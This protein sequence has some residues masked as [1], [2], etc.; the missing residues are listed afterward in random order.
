MAITNDDHIV[1]NMNDH[2]L[3][4]MKLERKQVIGKTGIELGLFHEEF[5]PGIWEDLSKNEKLQNREISIKTKAG[6]EI[7]CLFSTEK[8]ELENK[9]SWLITIVDVS[10]RKKAEKELADVYNRVTDGFVALDKNWNYTYVNK[11]AGIMMARDPAQM[12]GKNVW[13]EF[14]HL[15]GSDIQM[16][17]YR[18][19]EKHEMVN[20]E[21]YF[22]PQNIWFLHMIYPSADALSV[23]FKDIS[24]RKQD[25]QKVAES[26]LRFRTL[27]K[28][29]PVGIFETDAL[30]LTTYVNETWMEFTGLS[31]EE[32]I[33]D[34][35]MRIIHP[36]D[37]EMQVINWKRKIK[38]AE[39][40]SSE[41]RIIDKQGKLRWVI[42]KAIPIIINGGE[43]A[44][45]IGTISDVTGH[46]QA[47]ELLQKN[48]E[49][50]NKA[51]HIAKIGSWEFSLITG[52]LTWS[53]ELYRIFELEGHSAETLYE[54]YRKKYHP[55][56][57]QKL[58]EI[59]SQAIERATGYTYEHRIMCND[60]SIK[61]ILG[62]AEVILDAAGKVIGLKGTGQDITESKKYEIEILQAHQKIDT[63]IN[64]IEGIVWEADAQT[65]QFT[66]ISKKVEDVL[67]YPAHQWLTDHQ[68]WAN[69][70]HPDD[71]K[72]TVDY[73]VTCTREKRQHD[74]EYRML[75]KDGTVVWL[76]DIVTVIVENDEPI[77]LRG[78]MI[79]IT[80]KKKAEVILNERTEEL[81]EL[82]THLQ[83][84]REDERM[85][86]AREI[87]DELGQQL[88]GLKMDIAWLMKKTGKGDA[89]IETK[90]ND[91]LKLVD[92]TVRT[93]RRISTELR[94]SI[95]DDLG[96]N[97]ALEWL[98]AEFKDRL[99][100]EMVY[101]NSF[102]D[103]NVD[104][105]ISIG[106]FRILQESLNN[107]AKHA[108][109]NKVEI[110][111]EKQNSVVHLSVHDD[112]I[113]F[114]T[115]TKPTG[116]TFG[117]LGIRERVNRMKGDCMITSDPGRGTKIE[118]K[119]P[120]Q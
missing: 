35:W 5:A 41:Y 99:R 36:D 17:Y 96:L 98:M 107:I 2:L 100:I 54:A 111:I 23:F 102:D 48:E 24:F 21:Q 68:F 69:H 74:F 112:G 89:V 31:F 97:A 120:L 13:V 12:I 59:I 73:C 47:M 114:D 60:G 18:A 70:I 20:L 39:V 86:I 56:D 91:T 37:R 22:P 119:I 109:A 90:F 50:L 33:G 71:R 16:A 49:T 63:L 110:K 101:D 46:K 6:E 94:P 30:G 28:S 40:S 83:N 26:E 45:Y 118:V 75:A 115:N 55:E 3:G 113:G 72:M 38:S 9:K 93:I 8:L 116:L 4:L 52:E 85:N 19:M 51:Q 14:P 57:L 77:Q 104:P 117:V 34:K 82:A 1:T 27:T 25:E 79:N 65:F 106:L 88:T 58:D 15:V 62:I 53:K 78:V 44:G 61:Y 29:A 66:Y 43:I 105:N 10:K 103:H 76:R 32:S 42:G 64:T 95:I 87:H 67:G 84:V 92:A 7:D 80:E 108:N 11:S 81:R